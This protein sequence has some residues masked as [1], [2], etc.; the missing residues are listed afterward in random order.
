MNLTE[1][2]IKK[3]FFIIVFWFF[4][5]FFG[6]QSF[7]NLPVSF[8]AKDNFVRISIS[9]FCPGARKEK[10]LNNITKTLEQEILLINRDIDLYS[11]TEFESCEVTVNFKKAISQAEAMS[12]IFLAVNRAREKF[13]KETLTPVIKSLGEYNFP[14]FSI[15]VTS[16]LPI[17]NLYEITHDHIKPQL[18]EL[19]DISFISIIDKVE[20]QATIELDLEKMKERQ[21]SATDIQSRLKNMGKNILFGENGDTYIL[22][23]FTSLDDIR[24]FTV[25]F[26]DNDRAVT[27][28]D[29]ANISE[30]IHPPA[31]YTFYNGSPCLILEL[32]ERQ[33]AN[34]FNL[35]KE[36][37]KR[38]KELKKQL[39]SHNVTFSIL[40]N[41][42]PN[43]IPLVKDFKKNIWIAIAASFLIIWF[44]FRDFNSIIVSI[45][46]I[47]VSLCGAFWILNL[48]GHS[49][50]IYTILAFIVSTGLIIDDIIIIREDIYRHIELGL[51]PFEATRK[52]MKEMFHP[53]TGTTCMLLAVGLSMILIKK[54]VST[55]YLTS[56][57]ITLFS[58]MLFSYLEALT[59]GPLLCAYFLKPN[60][61]GV[62]EKTVFQ[63]L[64]EKLLDLLHKYTRTIV[65]ASIALL[66]AGYICS[67]YVRT[68]AMPIVDVGNIVIHKTLPE[69][70]LDA[71]KQNAL[72]YAQKIRSGYPDIENIGIRVNNDTQMFYLQMVSK[73]ER[74]ISPYQLKENLQENLEKER[75]SGGILSYII[76]NNVIPSYTHPPEYSLELTSFNEKQLKEYAQNI[77]RILQ[78]SN[79]LINLTDSSDKI[80]KERLILLNQQKMNQLG[81]ELTPLSNELN[82][83]LNG[84]EIYSYYIPTTKKDY[85]IKPEISIKKSIPFECLLDKTNAFNI[86]NKLVP[87]KSFASVKSDISENKEIRR[88]NGQS[89]IEISGTNNP[90]TPDLNAM[91]ITDNA[92]QKTF[93]LPKNISTFWQGASEELMVQKTTAPRLIV[94]A[95]FF[96]YM[97]L[98]L[99]YQSLTLPFII[100]FP[101]PFALTG[102]IIALFITENS[103]NV[104]SNIGITLTVGIA[105]KNGIILLKYANQLIQEGVPYAEAIYTA[106]KIRLRP[107]LM[108]MF[109]VL[110]TTIPI[111]IPWSNYSK[112][113]F[114]LGIAIIGGLIT[115]TLVNLLIIPIFFQNTYRVY[116]AMRKYFKKFVNTES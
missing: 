97:T 19:G 3:P 12:M 30:E 84:D 55:Q 57:G 56:F 81:V 99:L 76:S 45:S 77:F 66:I 89:L 93:P 33:N 62:R 21:I 31:N 94:I 37:P 58:C 74:T 32:Y 23:D 9:T 86:N 13:P 27:L 79:S 44:V 16:D 110:L 6:I 98:I 61:N 104:F 113:Q 71:S 15:A 83:L 34:E 114:S 102:S 14:L 109:G 69:T 59:L 8:V 28:Q 115:S 35:E 54:T 65:F 39:S 78:E 90:K 38:L 46:S 101:L 63:E 103:V 1:F 85:S 5:I 92:L 67:L 105:A 49:L 106:V 42:E 73:D 36:V 80:Q 111:L 50:N 10:V 60:K 43:I 88:K 7:Y 108:T 48:G 26:L 68:E 75:T 91:E 64:S 96:I 29:I 87:L 53:V 52:G 40:S 25:N 47:P 82:L 11:V 100:L 22:G 116:L 107:I 17:Q 95:L 70:S 2:S 112:L 20:K 72:Q 18:E 24:S 41:K 4:I 51:S